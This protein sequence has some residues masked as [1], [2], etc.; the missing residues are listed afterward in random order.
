MAFDND[1]LLERERWIAQT[2]N[3]SASQAW[4]FGNVDSVGWGEFL[5]PDPI[6]F[7]VTFVH[8]PFVTYGHAVL[9]DDR[10]VDGRFPRATGGVASWIT[11]GK[12]HYTGAHVYVT[13]ATADPLLAAQAYDVAADFGEDPGYEIRH[14][15]GFTALAIKDFM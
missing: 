15:F 2:E 4:A 1:H 13:V 7:G 5:L 14:S 6:M 11:T 8:E 12:D 10:L 3:N 9:D